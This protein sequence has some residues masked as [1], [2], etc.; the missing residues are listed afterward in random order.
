MRDAAVRTGAC[1]I[2]VPLLVFLLTAQLPWSLAGRVVRPDCLVY[3]YVRHATGEFKRVSFNVRANVNGRASF[4]TIAPELVFFYLYR[5]RKAPCVLLSVSSP[6]GPK[7][8][9]TKL[10]DYL[11]IPRRWNKEKTGDKPL[12]ASA[13]GNATAHKRTRGRLRSH[14]LP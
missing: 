11:F 4:T 1:P 14:Q 13:T 7:K 8:S 9:K 2:Y 10:V 3:N 5:R 12:L 6:C